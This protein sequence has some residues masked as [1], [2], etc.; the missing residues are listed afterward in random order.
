MDS[1]VLWNLLE[2][3]FCSWL[4]HIPM[5]HQLLLLDTIPWLTHL[6]AFIAA[7]TE[8]TG[9]MLTLS[10]WKESEM[11]FACCYRRFVAFP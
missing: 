10:L 6:S 1:K 9:K 11:T 5:P 7:M 8:D 4:L 2:V 3:K